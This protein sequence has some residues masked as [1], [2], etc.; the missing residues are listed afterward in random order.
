ME[1]LSTH[2]YVVGWIVWMSFQSLVPS[3][4]S[5]TGHVTHS[6]TRR[7][8]VMA[9]PLFI[10][11]IPQEESVHMQQLLSVD[12]ALHSR[13]ACTRFLRLDRIMNK[14]EIPS[15][16]N[17][18]VVTLATQA[19][20]DALRAP[21]G[22]NAQPYKIILVSDPMQKEALSKWCCGHNAHRV[23]DSDCT[24]VFLADRQGMWELPAYRQSLLRPSGNSINHHKKNWTKFQLYK[25]QVL[26]A[27]FSQGFP[28]PY[29]LSAPIGWML[30]LGMRVVSWMTRRKLPIPTL[31]NPD[32]W[33]QKNTMLVAMA[34]LL[35]CT[36][37]GLQTCPMEGYCAWGIKQALQIPRRYSI[38]LIVATGN[39]YQQQQSPSVQQS[40]GTA[41]AGGADDAGMAHGPQSMTV[42]YPKGTMIFQNTFRGR[43]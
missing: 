6:P 24:A 8:D 14:T 20:E 12:Q 30:R 15:P 41:A 33:A 40:A 18:T 19:L 2:A 23:R 1:L 31:S 16:S 21:S 43:T 11:N 3:V 42:R 25:I 5:W 28:L 9:F 13:Y 32:T 17:L 39:A 29:W 36:A 38:P 7:K 37:R 27:L 10:A 22:F 35:G 4:Q 34:Y 26:V